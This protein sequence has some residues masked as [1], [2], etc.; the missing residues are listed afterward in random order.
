MALPEKFPAELLEGEII[1]VPSSNRYHQEI[2]LGVVTTMYK[3]VKEWDL[4]KVF[5][6]FDVRLGDENVVRPDIISY[7]KKGKA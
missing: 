7:R 2:A 1:M 6:E 5:C 4:G 3:I